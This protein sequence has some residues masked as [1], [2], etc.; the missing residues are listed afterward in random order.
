MIYFFIIIIR[1]IKKDDE[2]IIFYPLKKVLIFLK[3][4]SESHASFVKVMLVFY[5]FIFGIALNYPNCE[6]LQL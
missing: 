4:K 6:V 1:L 5:F 3:D 2:Y